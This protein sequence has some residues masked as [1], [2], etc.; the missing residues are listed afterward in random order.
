MNPENKAPHTTPVKGIVSGVEVALVGLAFSFFALAGS[1]GEARPLVVYALLLTWLLAVLAVG[2]TQRPWLAAG[3]LLAL[4]IIIRLA[5]LAERRMGS[6]VLSVTWEAI[7]VTL[8]GGN[9]YTHTYAQSIPP[10]QNPFAYPPGNLLFYL[11][12]FLLGD[13]RAT[14]IFSSAVVLVGLIW[15]AWLIRNDWPIAAMGVYAAAP[16][17]IALATDNSNDTSAGALLFVSALL[18][19]LARRQSSAWLLLLAALAMGEALAFKLYM[20]PFWPF[21]IAYLASQHWRLSWASSPNRT[22]TVPA[23]LAYAGAS[24]AFV[25]VVTLPFFLRSPQG[26]VDSLTTWSSAS[27]HPIAGWNVWAFLGS[28]R[29]WDIEGA[30]GENLSRIDVGLMAAAIV[31]GLLL[32]VRRPSRALLMGVGVW[33]VLMFFARWTTYAYFAGVAPVVLLIPFADRLVERPEGH[34][35]AER[36]A[37]APIRANPPW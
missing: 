37:P 3:Y 17:L 25:A 2:L 14:E 26:F 16:S 19:L 36:P 33:F 24:A 9:P 18:L 23:W 12:G 1:Q 5:Y 8:D 20:L 27:I 10:G 21:F 28:W 30:L 11:P 32:G 22:L 7:D 29:G 15:A 34:V 4:G 35:E 31:I 13:V 6:D